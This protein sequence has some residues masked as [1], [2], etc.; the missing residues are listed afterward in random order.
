MTESGKWVKLPELLKSIYSEDEI[1][2]N[3]KSGR[4]FKAGNSFAAGYMWSDVANGAEVAL[5]VYTGNKSVFGN[6]QITA[7]ALTEYGVK[8]GAT[9][10]DNGTAITEFHRNA[11][12][13]IDPAA[14]AYY[15]PVYT[16]GIVAIPRSLGFGS[17]TVSRAGGSELEQSGILALETHYIIFAKNVSGAA[18]SR[19]GIIVDWW[20]GDE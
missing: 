3:D 9:I 16:G 20:Q 6:Y 19:M 8:G 10:T 15:D 7:T 14:T 4:K 11:L 2:I 18:Q 12:L 13:T 5:H 1:I 17:N